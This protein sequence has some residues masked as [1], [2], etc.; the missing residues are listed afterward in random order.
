MRTRVMDVADQ[1]HPCGATTKKE[2]QQYFTERLQDR[3]IKKNTLQNKW[4]SSEL[5]ELTKYP[6][7]E[8]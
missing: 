6:S 1:A 4:I 2:E 8:L 5:P 3:K 7:T